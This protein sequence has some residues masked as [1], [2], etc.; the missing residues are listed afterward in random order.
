M[1]HSRSIA[2]AFFS[3]D[4]RRRRPLLSHKGRGGIEHLEPEDPKFM[5][6]VYASRWR[7]GNICLIRPLTLPNSTE[8]TYSTAATR[9]MAG[10][11]GTRV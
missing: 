7:P 1:R 2:S 11:D 5:E 8:P 3:K 4:G 6:T 10:P 9:M